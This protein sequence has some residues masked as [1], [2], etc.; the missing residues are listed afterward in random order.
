MKRKE[1]QMFED[2]KVLESKVSEI[3]EH[4]KEYFQR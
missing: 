4:A 3:E 1:I 2:T